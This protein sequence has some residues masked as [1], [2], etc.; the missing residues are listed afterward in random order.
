MMSSM[1]YSICE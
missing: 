1:I